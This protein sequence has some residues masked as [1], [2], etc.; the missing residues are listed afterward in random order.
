MS[1]KKIGYLLEKSPV[2]VFLDVIQT[3]SGFFETLVRSSISVEM[4]LS[5]I[6]VIQ[7]IIKTP[8]YENICVFLNKVLTTTNY[9]KQIENIL[10]ETTLSKPKKHTSNHK[11]RM[12]KAILSH[13]DSKIWEQV[14]KLLCSISKH[15]KSPNIEFMKIISNL[16]KNNT[17]NELNLSQFEKKFDSLL[18]D[19]DSV[20]KQRTKT[21]IDIY[22]RLEELKDNRKP[23][24]KPNITKGHFDCVAHYIDVHMVII[25][26]SIEIIMLVHFCRSNNCWVVIVHLEHIL[27]VKSEV[28]FVCN[29][30]RIQRHLR[31]LS[32]LAALPVL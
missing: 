4:I 25:F 20:E 31:V 8:F 9:W 24:V 2:N 30:S 11:K 12:N 5:T 21:G 18:S 23:F 19:F 26:N 16:I 32:I 14:Y 10:K 22:P 1:L 15:V 17:N 13:T 28:A 6:Q 3:D 29:F 27:T 7:I